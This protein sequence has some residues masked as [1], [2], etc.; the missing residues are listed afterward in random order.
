MTRKITR[1]FLKTLG[2]TALC[3]FLLSLV[4]FFLVQ[5][6]TFQTW[7]AHRAGTW[8]SRELNTT[9]SIE[10]VELELFSNA[11][12]RNVLLLDLHKDTLLHGDVTTDISGFH[13]RK[14]KLNLDRIILNKVTAKVVKYGQDSTFNFQFLADYFDGGKKDTSAKGW[15]VKF[16]DLVL[17]DVTLEYSI[18]KYREKTGPNINFDD[19]H[20][21]H[22]SGTIRKFR[23]M[24][25]TIT[26]QVLGLSTHELRSDFRLNKLSSGISLSPR[27]LICEDLYIKTPNS[28]VNGALRFNS[29]SWD[30]Y[31]DF[32]NQVNMDG[33]LQNG[34]YISFRDI[35][36]FSPELNGL[37]ETVFIS[38]QVKGTVS[39]M[40]LK[41]IA[42]TYG[43]YT[44]FRGN[45]HLTGLPDIKQTF[46]HFDAKALSAN[47]QDLVHL[48]AY[49]F[50]SL[51][52]LDIPV[53]LSRLGTVTYKGKFDGFISDFTT[54]GTF[55]TALGNAETNLSIRIP[56]KGEIAY[57]GK[58]KTQHFNAGTLAGL[59][60]FNQLSLSAD[61]NG[62]GTSLDK[63]E[64][65]L[66]GEISSVIYNDYQ[67]SGI[68]LNGDFSEKIFNGL[69]TSKD[70]NADFDFNGSINFQEKM[71]KMDFISTLN[72]LNLRA[73]HFTNKQD[74]GVL[75]SQIL[76]NV[77]GNSIENLS[78]IINFDNTIY[79]TRTRTFKLSTFEIQ[80][81]QTE[82]DKKVRLNSE[83][84]N[85]TLLGQFSYNNL[86]PAVETLLNQYYPTYFKKPVSKKILSDN[87]SFYVRIK[88]FNTINELF[89]PDYM[90]SPNTVLEGNLNSSENKLNLQFRS[91]LARYGSL[92]A[93][94]LV[95]I[96]NENAE[97]VI[98]EASGSSFLVSDS[99]RFDNYNVVVNSRDQVSSYAID[100]DNLRSH[101][102][103]GEVKGDV[104]FSNSKLVISNR[105]L[106]VALRDSIW[107]QSQAGSITLEKGGALYATPISIG[108]GNQKIG[109]QG[110]L[111]SNSN[112]TLQ[113]S[114]NN[115]V[116]QQFNP[117]L[118][119]FYL[120]LE[121]VTNGR[122]TLNNVGPV[123]AY[124]GF[125]HM[126][127]LRIN[128]NTIGELQIHTSYND[129]QKFIAMDGYT[130]LGIR[131]ETGEVAKN[132]AFEGTYD[133][134]KKDE[135]INV[136]FSAKPANL[137]LL[138]P[139]LEGI[140]TIKKGF[141]N[142][143]GK[144]H[145]NPSDIRIDGKF[146]LFNSEIKV[147]YTNV[148]YFITGDI[149]VMPDQI[150]FSDL[151]M[152]EVS[153][154]SAAQGTINGNVFHRKFSRW[155]IDYDVTY[156][157]MLVLNTTEKENQ[158]F[159]GR[160]F[161]TGNIGIY[162]YIEDLH[163]VIDNTTNKHSRFV[164]PL[165]GPAEIGESDF[166]HFV[167]RD[168]GTVAE[169]KKITG[170]S[171]D[172][173]VHATP[174]AQ[175]QIIID[176]KNGDQLNVQ[177]QGDLRLGIN[178]L[179]KFEMT[180]DYIMTGGDYLF[181][182]ENV[183]NKK[184][185]IEAG[186]SISWSGD[187]LNADID[188]VTSYRQ[189]ASVAPLINETSSEFK[190]RTPVDC[191][192][193]I[194]DKLFTPNI[195]FAIDFPNIDA[196]T[197]SRISSVLSDETELN[198]QVFSFLLFRSFVTPLIYNA[199]GGGVTAGGAA[200]STGSELLSNRVSEF[201]NTYFGALS[202]IRDLQL[203][204]NY[205]AGSG[206]NNEAVDLNLS[207]QFLDNKITVDGNFGVNNNSRNSNSL[208]GDV[209]VDYKLT[210]DG[211][212][213]LKGFNRSNDN[214]QIATA[215]G[216]YTQ[217]VGFFY[218]VEFNDLDELWGK[219]RKKVGGKK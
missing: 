125:L 74:S 181:T 174:D 120:K 219:F 215:G 36:A 116:M 147:D 200:A 207:K 167:K 70:P 216:P 23:M 208:I 24:H 40:R 104:D 132:I 8:L 65:S 22:T 26:L 154:K 168:T 53:I 166:I 205:R 68:H 115:L 91:S 82:S 123:L 48:P 163:M 89:L 50:D 31:R 79:K 63:L 176:K 30:D 76:I 142:G 46:L 144:I 209:N 96:L 17:Q 106:R 129:S 202:G 16:G 67:Y 103:K 153:T 66:D 156:K 161:G 84:F 191:K 34:T 114:I 165:D 138:N 4:L 78:G 184:F 11:R 38:G 117:L 211:R 6:F 1:I 172:M 85:A 192:L 25:D 187:P 18:R 134:E 51:K 2:I 32:I 42:L 43:R 135:S 88:K 10:R 145:G 81:E 175:A 143:S 128:N 170:F 157:N 73:L 58:I 197:R 102:N 217:G 119:M 7:L 137:S 131:D 20:L 118:Q 61:I 111:T 189:R 130:S 194:T 203:G 149:E 112:D 199:N 150:R 201:L 218:R 12:L 151:L 173:L 28:Y 162:G 139:F 148:S 193:V 100:W 39:D 52:K 214:T 69:I 90:L 29:K 126:R 196:T 14:Q 41:N 212:F 188:I 77:K 98:A 93:K 21:K 160:L 121:G 83:Y 164:L 141:V 180:G 182:L 169:E 15:D 206:G 109:I 158:S 54:Y 159:Y 44:G 195:K 186:S 59:S 185:E 62:S 190:S 87:I 105:S 47:Y 80:A 55:K 35:A 179:G 124:N 113:I 57:H 146:R 94:D 213:R 56:E 13:F 95:F 5:T 27:H 72:K 136:D 19:V 127:D 101:S 37:T 133:L 71:P 33:N 45:A 171:L 92:R 110:A 108:C 97:A 64:A 75:S 86:Q 210:D 178:T 183:I 9:V 177:G 155:Q 3:L 198:R 204:L 49:P 60:D 122:I 152:R 140:L 99:L 107:E